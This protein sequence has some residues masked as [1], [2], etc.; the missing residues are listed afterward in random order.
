V[1]AQADSVVTGTLGFTC[2]GGCQPPLN[3][4]YYDTAPTSGSFTYDK[5]TQQF[6]SFS[7]VWD[8]WTWTEPLSQLTQAD[9]LALI[10]KGFLQERYFIGCIEG[11]LAPWPQFSCDQTEW[12]KTWRSGNGMGP[13]GGGDGY[14]SVIPGPTTYPIDTADGTMFVTDLDKADKRGTVATPEPSGLALSGIGAVV[15]FLL[16]CRWMRRE[17]QRREQERGER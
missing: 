9:Y 16:G 6:L 17:Q 4:L 15:F 1:A 12:F 8:G 11:S 2:S 5:T 3:N 10:G 13:F 14:A 7:I